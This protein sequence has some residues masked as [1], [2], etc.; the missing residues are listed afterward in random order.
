MEPNELLE[1]FERMLAQ[2]FPPERARAIDAG[3][4]WDA[5]RTEVEGSG[6]LDALAPADAGGAGLSFAAVAP[7]FIAL[8]RHAAPLEIGRAMIERGAADAAQHDAAG[9]VLLAAAIA[10]AGDRLLAMSVAY[11]GERVQ[12]GKPIGRQQ[13]LQQQLAVMAEDAVSVRLA[14]ELACA[15]GWPTAEG[16]A[17][18]KTIASAA[19]PRMANTA[20]AVHGAIG[21]SAEYDLQLYTRRLHAWR[22]QDGAES[23]WSARLGQALLADKAEAV[24]W[25]RATFFGQS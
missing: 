23:L 13:A 11:A 9:A 3:G 25:V 4:H 14:V 15:Q 20:H 17:V 12:F 19:A 21:I 18:A 7:L 8:G 1:P 22:R 16:A 6:F 2:L 5:E 10:G 24:D